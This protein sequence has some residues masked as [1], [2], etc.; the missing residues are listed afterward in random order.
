MNPLSR[1]QHHLNRPGRVAA[2]TVAVACAGLAVGLAGPS[3]FPWSPG[4]LR[5]CLA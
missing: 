3:M 1:R 4:P 2:A 5:V